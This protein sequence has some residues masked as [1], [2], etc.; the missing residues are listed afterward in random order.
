M[1]VKKKRLKMTKK[2]ARK[3]WEENQ[4]LENHGIFVETQEDA[5][6]DWGEEAEH[7]GIDLTTYQIWITTH[8]G[9]DPY[10][11]NSFDEVIDFLPDDFFDED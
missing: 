1:K 10:G 7:D 2:E 3:E 9:I 11:C 4:Y 6:N 8:Y 5:I